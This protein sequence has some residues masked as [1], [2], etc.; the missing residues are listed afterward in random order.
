MSVPKPVYP[1]DYE[2]CNPPS[3]PVCC[4]VQEYGFY[5]DAVRL[6][7]MRAWNRA[8]TFCGRHNVL[9]NSDVGWRVKRW[10]H[11]SER[12]VFVSHFTGSEVDCTIFAAMKRLTMRRTFRHWSDVLMSSRGPNLARCLSPSV[13]FSVTCTSL[14]VLIVGRVTVTSSFVFVGMPKGYLEAVIT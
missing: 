5:L 8:L 9:C 3:F 6:T 14:N 1:R 13:I 12:D 7:E 4:C 2:F 11:C 10:L